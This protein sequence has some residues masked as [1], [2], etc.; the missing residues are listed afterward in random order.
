VASLISALQLYVRLI[1]ISLR[2][3]MQYRASFVM[4]TIGDFVTTGIE[5]ISVWVLFQRFNTVGG[6]TFNEITLF[7]GTGCLAFAVADA[8][9]AGFDR[10]GEMVKAGDF[11]RSLLRPRSTALQL[12]GQE[13]TLRRIGRFSQ[14]LFVF[15]YAVSVLDIVWTPDKVVLAL[16]SIIGGAATFYAIV[17]F[18]ATLAFW[19]TEGL[20]ITN[21]AVYG[22]VETIR[23]PLDIYADW[24]RKL[25]TFVIPLACVNY[26]PMLAV[27]GRVETGD[28]GYLLS[29]L[30]PVVG[31]AFLYISLRIWRVGVR[32]YTST[33]S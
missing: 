13:L 28:P 21:A 3:Q 1:S 14:V 32:H 11:D 23:Y 29:W 7:H 18:Q 5:F 31:Y 10:F 33:G 6:W 8:F 4:L 25:F 2:G 16:T 19:T 15:A 9:S 12:A 27:L 20:E 30:S 17:V 24:F 22:G 26:Y